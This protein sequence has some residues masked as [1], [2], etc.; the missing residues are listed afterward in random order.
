MSANLEAV[1]QEALKLAP[2]E[3]LKLREAIDTQLE[4]TK[5]PMTED[6]FEEMLEKRGIITRATNPSGMS[7]APPI[8]IKGKPLSETIIE[9]RR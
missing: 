6:E 1:K 8:T 3:L 5:T 9:E 2:E 7:N 4:Q